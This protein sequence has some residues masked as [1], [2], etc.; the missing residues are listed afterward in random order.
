M[1]P[2]RWQRI[3]TLC[4]ETLERESDER[5]GFLDAA[6]SGDADLRREVESLLKY[7]EP[8]DD[9]LDRSTGEGL[10]RLVPEL[11]EPAL[12][13]GT[14]I[15]AYRIEAVLGAGGMGKVYR[16]VDTRL[17]RAVALKFLNRLFFADGSERLVRE[18]RAAARL[19]HP[20][21]CS[22]YEVVEDEDGCFIAMQYIEGET[23]ANRISR[24]PIDVQEALEITS[25]I[26]DALS[27]AHAKGIVHRDVKPQ[28][29]MITPR[30]QAKVLD[31]GLA[32]S[33]SRIDPSICEVEEVTPLPETEPIA[34]T[35]AYMSPEQACGQEVD[36][37]TDLYSLTVVLF[38]MA[39]GVSPFQ[40]TTVALT[41]DAILNH[42]PSPPR[43]INASLPVELERIILKGLEKDRELRYQSAAELLADVQSL[44]RQFQAEHSTKPPPLVRR[45]RL[46]FGYA[47]AALA[48]ASVVA[49]F[50]FSRSGVPARDAGRR[51][52]MQ[53]TNFT[54]SA[55]NPAVSRDGRMLTFIRGP[56][57]FLDPGQVYARFL[58]DGEPVPLTHDDDRK[59]APVFSPDGSRIAYT[60]L[61]KSGEWV[62][63]SVSVLGGQ[64][65]L[66]L[67][68]AAALT[69]IGDRRILFSEIKR[70]QHMAIVAGSESRSDVRDVYVPPTKTGMAHRSH[71][72]PDGRWVLIA[73]EMN[74]S[75]WLPCQVV[76]LEGR[77][78]GRIVGPRQAKCTYA[79]WSPDG[80]WMYLSADVGEGFHIW[81]QRFPD[82][83]PQQITFGATEDEGVAMW[84]DGRSLV[85]SVGTTISS[86]W[87]HDAGSER[88]ITSAGYGQLPSF[89]ADGKKL[90]Y[91]LR[92]SAVRQ[93][94]S[95]ELW[96]VD[97]PTGGQRRILDDI[98]MG[99][100][101]VS[102][103]GTRVVFVRTD[104]GK[105]GVWI[106]RLDGGVPPT[107]V[108]SER[109][110]GAFFGPAGTIVFQAEEGQA[111][112]LF[113][114][115]EDGSG[116]QKV[117]ADPIIWVM[118]VSPGGRWAVVW[119]QGSTD[120]PSR[121]LVAYPLDGGD[122]VRLCDDCAV[123]NGPTRGNQPPM[124][125]WS[126]DGRNLYITFQT[127]QIPIDRQYETGRT[128]AVRLARASTLP[129]AFTDE[130]DV[131]STPDVLVIPHGAIFP[132]PTP[133]LYA[134]TRTTT[135][136][137]I[138]RIPVP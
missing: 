56:S 75:G 34:G 120:A 72:S 11:I 64:P 24:S 39:T 54:D 136:R 97:L 27:E 68:N 63:R 101:E 106:A 121:P 73:S 13:P 35:V 92:R 70:D 81:R 117:I 66:M 112:Y 57:T 26:A 102:S 103:D 2:E 42:P 46:H 109:A 69:W 14:A 38:E 59:M 133:S 25:Q 3:E 40:N 77:Q 49:A 33:V 51:P 12:S 21:I 125:T 88:Q 9:P 100:Y 7:A 82:G 94:A 29:I 4:L 135:H 80:Q 37:R 105:E 43:T 58:P 104:P 10:T 89:S 85:S 118:S 124:L 30:G 52:Y 113:R 90:Y 99:R 132:G 50:V 116:R 19:D 76:P 17:G 16:A 28:N 115:R 15:R 122:A 78:A 8:A 74:T 126:P 47:L 62:T 86:I 107:Q 67:A 110:V 91:L 131:A 96:A 41:R 22:I 18:A 61:T 79:A 32:A 137:N 87:V 84:P 128:Y 93:W 119:T 127:L 53:L 129:P 48:F 60:V 83:M 31:F 134:Y 1:N 45:T 6:C 111:E 5:S 20:N 138:Y 23:L 108:S 98:S 44:S 114:A 36:A 55:T 71:L 123:V 130:T 65:R 95:G